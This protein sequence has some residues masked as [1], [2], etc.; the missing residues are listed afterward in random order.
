LLEA[1]SAGV[2]VVAFP[3]G[4]IPEV[5]ADGET[6]FLVPEKTSGAL[7]GR[8]REIMLLGHAP[9]RIISANARRAWERLYTV[10]NYRK[11][12]TELMERLVS[13]WRAAP[14]TALPQQ[15]K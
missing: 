1:F 11:N 14:E 12:V 10:E 15:R 4:G 7:A 13:D 6:G 3:V 8:M 2:P 5:I 9:L